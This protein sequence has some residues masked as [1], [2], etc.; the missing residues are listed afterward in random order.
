MEIELLKARGDELLLHL[1]EIILAQ[2]ALLAAENVDLAEHAGRQVG[3][4]FLIAA[5]FEHDIA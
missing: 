1:L 4:E 2:V 5:D 3:L